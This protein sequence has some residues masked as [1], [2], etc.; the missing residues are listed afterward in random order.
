MSLIQRCNARLSNLPVRHKLNLL[1]ALIALGVIALSVLAA[2]MQYLDLYQTRRDTIAAHVEAGN[3]VLAHYA[4]LAD[5]GQLDL[6]SAQAAA[7]EALADIRAP[8]AGMY[9]TVLG[10]EDDTIV[11]HPFR[12]ERAGSPLAGYKDDYGVAYN[13][14]LAEAARQGGGYVQYHSSKGQDRDPVLRV[15]YAAPFQ[16]WRWAV[17]T[18]A[19]VGDVQRQALVFTGIMTAAG[20]T[21]VLLVFALAWLIGSR[22]T[23]PL[24]KATAVAHAIANGR[25]D[26]DTRADGTDEPGRLLASMGQMQDQLHSVISATRQ[27]A[28]DHQQGLVSRRIATDG[29][30]GEYALMASEVNTLAGQHVATASQLADL[31]QS[32][33]HGD[34]E[35]DMPALPGEQAVLSDAMAAVKQNLL[36]IS[37]TINTLANAAADGD[38]SLRQDSSRFAHAFAEMV[39]GLN[40]LM[41]TTD[42]GLDAISGVLQRI[43]DGDLTVRMEGRFGGVFARIQDD[44]NTTVDNLAGIVGRIHDA[45]VRINQAAGEIA[46][47]NADLSARTEQ[48]AANLE[49][50]AASMEE[51][52]ATVQLNAGHAH[53]ANQLAGQAAGIAG[54]AGHEVSEAVGTMARIEQSSRKIADII[55]VIDGIAFQTNILALNAAVEAARA[56]E[57]GRGFAVVAGEVRTLAQRSAGAAKEIKALIDD[58]VAQVGQGVAQVNRAGGTMTSVVDSVHRV[59]TL[60]GQISEASNE[61]SSGI[62]QVS[63]TVTQMDQATQQNAAMVEEASAAAHAMESQARELLAAVAAFRLR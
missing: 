60:M 32:Y 18:G 35:P 56:G 17:T 16:P 34:L 3:S 62:A 21:L 52:T 61:Q 14:A 33:A 5:E 10:L 45:S 46:S 11:M 12:R 63:Q 57:Q 24:R 29:L 38:F 27:L 51:L 47:A 39:D 50:T 40:R 48:Q 9:Y 2:R 4:R 49:E 41:Q 58:S 23:G 6:A 25:L 54:Q 37:R 19:Y 1:T 44:A 22:I 53:Q 15:A 55:S 36:A 26:N 13:T 28:A 7:I 43:A 8:G 20:G 30:P 59:T 42:H 31:V